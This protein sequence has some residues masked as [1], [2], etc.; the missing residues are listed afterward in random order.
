MRLIPPTVL[1]L[2]LTL[3]ACNQPDAPSPQTSDTVALP[4]D[5]M[6]APQAVPSPTPEEETHAP[7]ETMLP[8]PTLPPMTQAERGEKGARA[9]LLTWARALENR[10]FDEAWA[11][12]RYPQ[13]SRAA[14]AQWWSRYRTIT[15]AVPG[16]EM[17]AGAGSLYYTAAA[18][19]T[20]VRQDGSRYRLEGDVV[21]RRVNDVDGAT[22]AQLRW[23][24]ESA[25][26][27]DVAVD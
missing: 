12:F 17:D 16:G 1:A 4:D 25:D 23:G 5:P 2:T 20:G 19:L 11:Q 3:S 22:P 14:F 18:V 6:T 15:V 21:L 13:S 9:V 10:R 7:P 24:I 8:S 26:L 27:K